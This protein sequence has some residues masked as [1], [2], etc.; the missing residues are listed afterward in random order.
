[1]QANARTYSYGRRRRG[2]VACRRRRG[3]GGGH[4]PPSP[5]PLSPPPHARAEWLAVRRGPCRHLRRRRPRGVHPWRRYGRT[6]RTQRHR[7]WH[8]GAAVAAGAARRET[9]DRRRVGC[10]DHKD[11]APRHTR[12]RQTGGATPVVAGVQA[13]GRPPQRWATRPWWPRVG[14]R[15]NLG[16]P[17]PRPRAHGARTPMVT[18]GRRSRPPGGT[19]PS[20]LAWPSNAQ[21]R[22]EW[23]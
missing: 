10:G 2:V 12:A 19:P 4:H 13:Q 14:R 11:V 17:A 5:P 18:T 20:P 3:G 6:P 16:H 8:G 1:M 22:E 7:C 15:R 23:R 9:S 21:K